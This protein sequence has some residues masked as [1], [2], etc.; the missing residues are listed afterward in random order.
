VELSE[1]IKRV[2]RYRDGIVSHP[3]TRE[4]MTVVLEAAYAEDRTRKLYGEGDPHGA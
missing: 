2:E 1:A 4:A 3:G